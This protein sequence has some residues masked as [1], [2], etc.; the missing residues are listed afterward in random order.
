MKLIK[1][2]LLYTLLIC[3]LLSCSKDE[4]APVIHSNPTTNIFLADPTIF[5]NNG[6]YYL[7]GTSQ[8]SLINKGNGFLVYSSTDM[9]NWEGPIGNMNGFALKDSEAFGNTG[10][11]APQVFEHNNQFYMAYTAN[12]K[13]A[14][15]SSISPLGPFTND[16]NPISK[17]SQIDPFIFMDDNGKSYLFHVRLSNGNRIFVAELNTD[18]LSIKE[19]TLTEIITA[20]DPWENTNNANWSVAEGPTVIKENDT[21]YLF[22]STNDF[23]NPDYAVGYATAPSPMG[24]WTKSTNNPIIHGSMI[25]ENGAGHGDIFYDEQGKMQYVL[26]THFSEAVVHP[27]KTG[28]IQL[29]KS[30]NN[31]TSLNETF[32]FLNQTT[33]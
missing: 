20:T 10:F 32:K 5:K 4:K 6:T 17:T 26:H 24:P 2:K 7:Y 1:N 18:L 27:R 23:R 29:T 30:D 14:I 9:Q 15:A 21:Y 33:N 8:G 28:T 13:I 16:G 11:W 19:E 25:G 31:I 22:Y 12:E 3:S